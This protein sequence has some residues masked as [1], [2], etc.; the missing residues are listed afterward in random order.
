MWE[1]LSKR[2]TGILVFVISRSNLP[3]CRKLESETVC[4]WLHKLNFNPKSLLP[5]LQ[6]AKSCYGKMASVFFKCV[7]LCCWRP[8]LLV[9]PPSPWLLSLLQHTP[10]GNLDCELCSSLIQ[11]LQGT[12]IGGQS[13]PCQTRLSY[14]FHFPQHG[15]WNDHSTTS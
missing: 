11:I 1:L 6:A 14:L 8:H 10:S 13:I 9:S 5:L 15:K 4:E 3:I 12:A 2:F 7:T